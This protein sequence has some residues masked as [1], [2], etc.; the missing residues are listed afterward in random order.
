MGLESLIRSANA[1]NWGGGGGGGGAHS[2]RAGDRPVSDSAVYLDC[3][4]KL[5]EWKIAMIEPGEAVDRNTRREALTLYGRATLVDAQSYRAWH[6]WGLSNYRALEEA[7][8]SSALTQGSPYNHPSA[9]EKTGNHLPGQGPGVGG[10]NASGRGTLL[11]PTKLSG[12]HHHHHQY[13]LPAGSSSKG[14]INRQLGHGHVQVP[15]EILIPLAVN[16]VKGL[17]RAI[18]LGTRKHSSSVAQDM[19]SVLSVWF[20]YGKIHE[21]FGALEVGLSTVHVDNWLGVIPQLIARID[22]SE[23]NARRLLH[24]LLIRLGTRH[25]QALVYPLSVALKSPKGNRKEAAES[26]MSS[27]RQHSAKLID[28]ALL[29]SHELVRVA[30]LWQE[31]WHESLEEASRQYFGDGNIQAMLDTLIPLH[32]TLKEGPN[33]LREA[34]FCQAYAADLHEAY[35]CIIAYKGYMLETGQP[36]PTSGA[37]SSAS[38]RGDRG[39]RQHTP[40]PAL[41]PL[42]PPL[43]REE[44]YLQQA[45]D[46]YYAVFKRINAELPQMTMLELHNVSPALLHSRD[47]DL[48]VPGTYSVSGN[49]VRIRNFGPLV[50]IIRSKQRPRKIKVYGEDGREFVFLLKGHEDLRQDERAMQLFG[51]VN[52]LLF[53]HPSTGRE[54]HDLTIQRY[55]VIPLSPT[56][57][58]IS[59]VPNCDTLHDLIRDFR[60][61]RKIILNVEHKLMQQIAPNQTYEML[62]HAHKLEVFEYALANTTGEDLAKILWLKSE[63]SETWLQR[64]ANYTRSL[65][66]MS[67]VGYVLGLGD[68]HPSNLMLD[69]KSGKVLHIDF[70]DCFEVAMQREKF[71]ER[72]P[73]RLTRMLV[74]AMEVSGIEGNYR[75]TCERGTWNNPIFSPASHSSSPPSHP[76]FPPSYPLLSSLSPPVMRVLREN[77]DS[78]VAMLEAFVYDPLISWRLLNSHRRKDR[79]GPEGR[80]A[81][82]AATAAAA[83]A[84]AAAVVAPEVDSESGGSGRGKEGANANGSGTGTATTSGGGGGSSTKDGA[85]VGQG[86]DG[87]EHLKNN[88]EVSSSSSRAAGEGSETVISTTIRTSPTSLNALP[89]PA[90]Y[91]SL[92]PPL[93]ATTIAAATAAA[94]VTHT[95]VIPTEEGLPP[96]PT[97]LQVTTSLSHTIVPGLSLPSSGSAGG[98]LSPTPLSPSPSPRAVGV[99]SRFAVEASLT[100]SPTIEENGGGEGDVRMSPRS[101]TYP[102]CFSGKPPRRGSLKHYTQLYK[103]QMEPLKEEEGNEEGYDVSYHE[104]R[105]GQGQEGEGIRGINVTTMPSPKRSSSSSSSRSSSNNSSTGDGGSNVIDFPEGVSPVDIVSELVTAI[106]FL[107][108][109][110]TSAIPIHPS[111]N[112]NNHNDPSSRPHAAQ[113]NV[114]HQSTGSGDADS[115]VLTPHSSGVPSASPEATRRGVSESFVSSDSNSNSDNSSNASGSSDSGRR[116]FVTAARATAGAGRNHGI[117]SSE[118]N[119]NNKKTNSTTNS[120]NDVAMG[121]RQGGGGSDKDGGVQTNGDGH[122]DTALLAVAAVAVEGTFPPSPTTLTGITF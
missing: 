49:A 105:Q 94:A 31:V 24:D 7:R 19:L 95:Q 76:P 53:H 59:W 18:N 43:A 35:E 55:A 30:I 98:H 83:A 36:I 10:L 99:G 110:T 84:T 118:N 12:G 29:V 32:L 86:L 17:M 13:H 45:W 72:V 25:A 88:V 65:A 47:L 26:L 93:S 107:S 121:Q 40:A 61:S 20:R 102:T 42:Q 50:A 16:A 111:D 90:T 21:V 92:L 41:S 33:T 106:P 81:A 117:A 38:R 56:A 101:L 71:P 109:M 75:L 14:S 70:G 51:L 5:G 64:R 58:L 113:R 89:P 78:L 57:G 46:L 44:S 115:L 108:S 69:R 4:L 74:N 37:A 9:T 80:A 2:A 79:K 52:A 60:E 39:S 6:Q 28:Q 62:P 48:G 82:A 67:M 63:T 27:L 87:K 54:S 68:R 23:T 1:N 15:A 114:S 103:K 73:F 8:G 22:H 112:D 119:D 104:K 122:Q 11:S 66:V 116:E 100:R 34:A 91:P 97:T 85:E 3:L 77:N 96:P 120:D